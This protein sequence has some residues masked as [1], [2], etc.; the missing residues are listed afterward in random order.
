[1]LVATPGD[2]ADRLDEAAAALVSAA[3]TLRRAVPDTAPRAAAGPA[4][5]LHAAWQAAVA[6]RA[7]EAAAAADRLL[8]AS[9]AVRTAHRGYAD[10]DALV[11]RHLRGSA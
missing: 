5:A 10:T 6:A 4:P 11:S 1:M 3:R 8:D 2:L 9:A 7:D